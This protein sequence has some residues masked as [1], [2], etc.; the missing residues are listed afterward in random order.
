MQVSP[1]LSPAEQNPFFTTDTASALRAVELEA[2]VL[3][4]GTAL[5]EYIQLILKSDKKAVRYDTITG[6]VITRR[7]KVMDITAFTMCRKNSL[8][9]VVFD[10]NWVS[11]GNLEKIVA[12]SP[13]G[14]LVELIKDLNS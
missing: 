3:L 6:Q 13:I 14:T 1:V 2:D 10:M 12:G 5:M 11:S 8:P 9:V 7:L 4:K